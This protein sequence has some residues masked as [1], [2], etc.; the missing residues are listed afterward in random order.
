[1]VLNFACVCAPRTSSS[2]LCDAGEMERDAGLQGGIERVRGGSTRPNLNEPLRCLGRQAYSE[3]SSEFGVV[4]PHRTS[5]NHFDEGERM[6]SGLVRG[7]TK[8]KYMYK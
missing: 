2:N 1:M 3:V 4:R 6:P 8:S 7:S 5:S